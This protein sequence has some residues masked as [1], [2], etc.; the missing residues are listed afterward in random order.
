[1]TLAKP[2]QGEE[3][4]EN[5]SRSGE[6]VG[7]EVRN[8]TE[9]VTESRWEIDWKGNATNR[10]L[11]ESSDGEK[12]KKERWSRLPQRGKSGGVDEVGTGESDEESGGESGRRKSSLPL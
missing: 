9:I 12:Q 3:R 8:E 10:R 5:G 2:W 7:R 6:G 11:R 4:N 1:M